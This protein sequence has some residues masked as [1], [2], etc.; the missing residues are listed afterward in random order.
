VWRKD[1]IPKPDK[2][3]KLQDNVVNKTLHNLPITQELKALYVASLGLGWVKLHPESA[4]VPANIT[5]LQ[6]L[7]PGWTPEIANKQ[8]SLGI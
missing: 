8:N 7:K 6:Q 5:S 4:D 3:K 1:S 2:F